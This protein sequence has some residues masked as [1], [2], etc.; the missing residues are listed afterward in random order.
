MG[1]KKAGYAG[2]K[3]IV[4]TEY[5]Q[6]LGGVGKM[7]RDHVLDQQADKD[8][9]ERVEKIHAAFQKPGRQLQIKREGCE[10]YTIQR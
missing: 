5:F 8:H 2:I 10:G 1:G 4:Q 7:Q 3:V 6:S 9:T